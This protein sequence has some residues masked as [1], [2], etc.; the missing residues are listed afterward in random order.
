[1]FSFKTG[2]GLI[3]FTIVIVIL[4]L[5]VFRIRKSNNKDLS[6]DDTLSIASSA[7]ST[8]EIYSSV[9]RSVPMYVSNELGMAYV[10]VLLGDRVCVFLIDTAWCTALIINPSCTASEDVSIKHIGLSEWNELEPEERLKR[11]MMRVN[12]AFR[13]SHRP[14]L[15]RESCVEYDSGCGLTLDG[16]NG[17]VNYVS[18]LFLC[19]PTR[20]VLDSYKNLVIPSSKPA[21][22][23]LVRDEPSCPHILTQTYI[24]HA[25]LVRLRF[26]DQM[27]DVGGSESS[28]LGYSE[29]PSKK[30]GGAYEVS[31]KIG[32]RSFK[33]IVDTGY[34]GEIT[35]GADTHRKIKKYLKNTELTLDLVGIAGKPTKAPVKTGSIRLFDNKIKCN[36]AC[37][38]ANDNLIGIQVLKRF[39]IAFYKNTL[40]VENSNVI[41][42][43]EDL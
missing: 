23:F 29:I 37:T 14:M 12:A 2:A 16:F 19:P 20:M 28:L 39:N 5:S 6:K 35:I 15:H 4:L 33:A 13:G 40:Y 11:S 31:V 10:N 17:R 25:G 32:D 9:V 43:K 34:S 18:D 36:I 1:M 42:M 3:L 38:S 41:G 27:M 26:R 22:V 8:P 30:T 21:E 24:E 7:R